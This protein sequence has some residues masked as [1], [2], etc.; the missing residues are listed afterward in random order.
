[1]EGGAPW[2]MG[3]LWARKQSQEDHVLTAS[4]SCEWAKG[5][6]RASGRLPAAL[7]ILQSAPCVLPSGKLSTRAG[8]PGPDVKGKQAALMLFTAVEPGKA[9][10]VAFHLRK[11]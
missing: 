9:R 11:P 6:P 1:M 3:G 8:P 5:A 2:F 7:C 4:V 10:V